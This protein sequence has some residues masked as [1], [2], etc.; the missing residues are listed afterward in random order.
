MSIGKKIGG[1]ISIVKILHLLLRNQSMNTCVLG[2]DKDLEG[3]VEEIEV[4]GAIK[5]R[6]FLMKK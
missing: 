6:N 2:S 3:E 1:S 4:D 5:M